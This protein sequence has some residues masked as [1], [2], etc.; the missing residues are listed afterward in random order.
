MV[1]QLTANRTVEFLIFGVLI[2]I[3]SFY[4]MNLNDRIIGTLKLE[5]DVEEPS[6]ILS[7][8]RKLMVD[9]DSQYLCPCSLELTKVNITL[10]LGFNG[11]TLDGSVFNKKTGKNNPVIQFAVEMTTRPQEPQMTY[12]AKQTENL[13]PLINST[14]DQAIKLR[15]TMNEGQ[16]LGVIN[17]PLICYDYTNYIYDQYNNESKPHFSEE[18]SG[19]N[20]TSAGIVGSMLV[21]LR[22]GHSAT[23]EKPLTDDHRVE[24]LFGVSKL[25]TDYRKYCINFPGYRE[26]KLDYQ[27]VNLLR[28]VTGQNITGRKLPCDVSLDEKE[29]ADKEYLYHQLSG[30]FF[31]LAVIAKLALTRN[32][33]GTIVGTVCIEAACRHPVT[34]EVARRGVQMVSLATFGDQDQISIS[35]IDMDRQ[36]LD[37]YHKLKTIVL[38]H[39]VVSFILIS[40]S[41]IYLFVDSP[42][43]MQTLYQ[44]KQKFTAELL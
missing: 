38:C 15:E 37:K 42:E 5:Y 21:R 4:M 43:R 14:N 24:Y 6:K 35:T 13:V 32:I 29:L 25:I 17:S 9:C 34:A 44:R 16:M 33:D 18:L 28:G 31:V 20:D 11:I 39:H 40:S 19:I 1:C 23:G 41:M 10:T 27:A 3:T 30:F 22:T 12:W 26:I 7:A 2:L 8:V 36:L